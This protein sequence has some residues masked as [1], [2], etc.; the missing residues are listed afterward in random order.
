M[1]ALSSI[2]S[3][4]A[5]R[6]TVTSI[7]DGAKSPTWHSGAGSRRDERGVSRLAPRLSHPRGVDCG[8]APA[9]AASES[10]ERRSSLKPPPPPPRDADDAD[11]SASAAARLRGVI[12]SICFCTF[13][14]R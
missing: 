10:S 6:S 11:P 12:S 2:P 1:Y 14:W 5:P 4:S 13:I 9:G 8:S 7:A 3:R